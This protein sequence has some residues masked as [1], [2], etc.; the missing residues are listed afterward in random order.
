MEILLHLQ[1]QVEVANSGNI[2]V[3]V[4]DGSV[5]DGGGSADCQINGSSVKSFFQTGIT[6]DGGGSGSS[7]VGNH[8][9]DNKD[10]IYVM[11]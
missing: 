3:T 1:L 11:V 10:N 4:D 8:H 5:T 9:W 7:R 6:A 2:L